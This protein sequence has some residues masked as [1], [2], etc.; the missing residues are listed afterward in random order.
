MLGDPTQPVVKRLVSLPAESLH[1]SECAEERLL[2][3][4][5]RMNRSPNAVYKLL[6]RALVE[7]RQNF[8]DTDSLS[9]ADRT[10]ELEDRTDDE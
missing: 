9:L 3:I 10:F 6:A 2:K 7:L 4:A 1:R 8:G 5:E